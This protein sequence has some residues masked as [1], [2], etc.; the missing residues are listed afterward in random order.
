IID[1]YITEE[2]SVRFIDAFVNNLDLK[3]L[4]FRHAE[5]SPTG[6]PPYDPADLLKLYIYGY[7]NRVRSSR[8]LE[9]ECKKNVEVMWL[10][11]KLIPD[12][13]TIADFRKDNRDAIKKVFKEFI[14]LCKKFEL[15]GNELVAIDSSKFSAVNSKKRNFNED[16]LKK[17]LKEIDEKID[18]YLKELE[19]NDSIKPDTIPTNAEKLKE[20]IEHLKERKEKYQDILKKLKNSGEKQVSLTDPDSRLMLNNKRTDVCYSV[21]ITVDE[22]NK[23]I[24][25]H[26]VVNEN[27]DASHLTE[28]SCRAKQILEVDKLKV[29]A[30]ANYSD[31]EEL[32]K[33]I[34]NGITP[35]IP[36]RDSERRDVQDPGFYKSKFRYDREKDVYICPA[37][38]ELRYWT[39]YTARKE[40]TYKTEKCGTCEFRSK[41]TSNKKGRI[42]TRRDGE[43]ALEDTKKRI[44]DNADMLQK[45]QELV[46][47][48][49]GT[50]K[51]AFNQGYMLLKRLPK[52][53]AE[54]SLTMLA[55][56]ITRVINIVGVEKL[57]EEMAT[58][59]SLY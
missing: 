2:N 50:I 19:E 40:R 7:L 31:S 42:L 47:H 44:K 41:C 59:N 29:V 48:P 38:N 33:C 1:D 22:K 4:G 10:L 28:L 5:L 52:V 54:I 27:N 51:R 14:L 13:K 16:K 43:N 21:H 15:F 3:E 56:D 46:E 9:K 36:D 26:E 53:G 23:L 8:F 12:F 18:R 20:K 39:T 58:V 37:G 17:R 24:L 49:F 30:D 6:R 35:Y 32:Q 11:K 45:R 25:D 55:Y 57:M 34:D